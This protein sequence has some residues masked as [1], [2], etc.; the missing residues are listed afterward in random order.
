MRHT[1]ESL[2]KS[3]LVPKSFAID[4]S[5][6]RWTRNARMSSSFRWEDKLLLACFMG[7]M[8]QRG[9]RIHSAC[10]NM[11]AV[12]YAFILWGKERTHEHL[13]VIMIMRGGVI[14]LV[15]MKRSEMPSGTR[16]NRSGQHN[17]CILPPATRWKSK[18]WRENT[19]SSARL[20]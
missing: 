20:H 7:V 1:L 2:G 5:S 12:D 14:N 19:P 11:C 15:T 16:R 13:N 18:V 8:S 10:T 17:T 9:A 3:K 4:F 6:H